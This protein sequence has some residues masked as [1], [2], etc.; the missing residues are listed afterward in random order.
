MQPFG[1]SGL[2][3][4]RRAEQTVHDSLKWTHDVRVQGARLAVGAGRPA[5]R[6]A[7]AA[8]VSAEAPAPSRS[9]T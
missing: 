2:E 6:P 4:R 7:H 9:L 8:A 3:T 5:T 1:L